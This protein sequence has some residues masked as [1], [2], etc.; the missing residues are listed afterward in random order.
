M[1]N[2]DLVIHD[3]VGQIQ[4]AQDASYQSTIFEGKEVC[5]RTIFV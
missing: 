2:S 5:K 4:Y 3:V 1:I